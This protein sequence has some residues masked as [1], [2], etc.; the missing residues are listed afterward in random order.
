VPE[1]KRGDW[2]IATCY[3]GEKKLRRVVYTFPRRVRN[4]AD[5]SDYEHTHALICTPEWFDE[6]RE[7]GV[8]F[9]FCDLRLATPEEIELQQAREV[10]GRG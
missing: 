4:R 7:D 9:P 10:A 1:F 5:W 2:V 3:G 8:G 6:G